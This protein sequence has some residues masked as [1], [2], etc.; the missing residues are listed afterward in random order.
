MVIKIFP[1]LKKPSDGFTKFNLTFKSRQYLPYISFLGKLK[2]KK[3]NV[4]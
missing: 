1:H 2:E 3:R 4:I